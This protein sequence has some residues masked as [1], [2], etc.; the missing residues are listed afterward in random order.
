M[1]WAKP[2]PLLHRFAAVMYLTAAA[3]PLQKSKGGIERGVLPGRRYGYSNVQQLTRVVQSYEYFKIPLETFV[4]DSQYMD[5]DQDFTIS[6]DFEPFGVSGLTATKEAIRAVLALPMSQ[7]T[8]AGPQ[9]LNREVMSSPSP[10]E[11]CL[12]HL[13]SVAQDVHMHESPSML[14]AILA[15]QSGNSEH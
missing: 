14:N 15:A 4:T 10:C 7:G 5:H 13:R 11:P 3:N 8:Q 6:P 12:L 2:G 1:A 9:H